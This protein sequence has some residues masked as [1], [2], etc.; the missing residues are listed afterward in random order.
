MCT[1][2]WCSL[3]DRAARLP[4]S[5]RHLNIHRKFRRVAKQRFRQVGDLFHIRCLR[6]R[7][8][9]AQR[10]RDSTAKLHSENA[11]AQRKEMHLVIGSGSRCMF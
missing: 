7:D 9:T 8:G 6:A 4:D 11:T 1:V 3:L 5:G 2:A 10:K